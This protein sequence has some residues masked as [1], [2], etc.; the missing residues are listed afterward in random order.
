M[1]EIWK[2]IKGYSGLYEVSN[3]G[4]VRSLDRVLTQ[5][6]RG[7]KCQVSFKGRIIRQT[8][9]PSG[10]LSVVISHNGTIEG[11]KVHTLVAEAFIREK[12]SGEHVH[13]RDFDPRNNRLENLEITTAAN[14]VN[15]SMRADR[16]GT[17][18]NRD[19]VLQ[20][21]YALAWG[22]TQTALA[23]QFGVGFPSINAIARGRNWGWVRLSDL[24]EHD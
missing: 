10:H 7:K 3:H 5:T 6:R 17:K 4:R 19:K 11:F 9:M 20:I 18:L 2:S 23:S 15:Y 1:K 22:E 13:H 24:A 16:L 8:S 12:L 21:K 14:N